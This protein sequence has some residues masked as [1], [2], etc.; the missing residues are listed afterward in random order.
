[1]KTVLYRLGGTMNKKRSDSTNVRTKIF[2]DAFKKTE[3]P[4]SLEDKEL[5]FWD[6]IIEARADWT[7][8][9]LVH[10]ANLARCLC[11]IEEE[12]FMLKI[13]GSVVDNAKGTKVMNPRHSIL[14]QL[15][16]RAITLSGKL[17][18]H[19]L[20]TQGESKL[21]N[22]KNKAKKQ[23]IEAFSDEDDLLAKP[24]H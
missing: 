9:D 8:I 14:E 11:S 2:S 3:P 5:P 18:I 22:G 6:T 23:A 24:V 15:S 16:R 4:V 17:H 19:A 13:E 10:A 21:Q 1:M 12:T 7:K 20:A